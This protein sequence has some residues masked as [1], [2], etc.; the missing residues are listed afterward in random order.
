MTCPPCAWRSLAYGTG[1]APGSD[2][3]LSK[4]SRF[5]FAV[6]QMIG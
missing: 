2:C 4:P 3:L 1:V 5:I 6:R